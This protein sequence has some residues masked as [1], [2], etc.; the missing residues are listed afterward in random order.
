MDIEKQAQALLADVLA[1]KKSVRIEK[2]ELELKELEEQTADP[3]LWSDQ[4]RAQTLTKQQADLSSRI[5]TWRTLEQNTR[6]LAELTALGDESMTEELAKQLADLQKQYDG[7]KTELLFA[8]QYDNHAAI[9]SIHAGAGGTDA[10]DWAQMLLRMYVR[11]A[12][13]GGYDATMID[14]S[15]GEEAGIKSATFEVSGTFAY[16]KLKAEHG[17][18]RLVRLSPFNSDNLRQTSFAKVEVVPKIDS[19]EQV[20]IDDKDLKID[21]YRSGGKGGQSVNTTDSAVRITHV[22]TGIVVAI[23][24]E[25]SQLQNKETALT[26]LRSKL[27]Q[28]QQ[29]QHLENV[30]ELKGPNEQAAWGNQIRSYVLHPYKQIKDLRTKYQSVDPDAVLDGR[31]DGFIT[32][33]LEQMVHTG[34]ERG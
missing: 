3:E 10:Q 18:H 25:R 2:L 17:V 16:G 6:D 15:A 32:A 14:E 28:L 9:V 31:L 12:E 24:N 8:G 33:Y 27:A 13:Q 1:A 7:L 5:T 23:Q 34:Q 19:P 22:P 11:W 26:I 4:T 30:A 29:E 20:Q 21:V